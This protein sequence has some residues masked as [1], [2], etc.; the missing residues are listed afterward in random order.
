M[1]RSVVVRSRRPLGIAA[2]LAVLA[3]LPVTV[4]PALA[5]EPPAPSITVVLDS[6][7]DAAQDVTFTSCLGSGCGQFVLDDDDDDPTHPSSVTGG[8]LSPGTYTVQQAPVAGWTLVD[9]DCDTGEDV[10][11]ASGTATIVLDPTEHVTCTFYDRAPAIRI[12]EESGSGHDLGFT[13]CGPAGCGPFTLD[14]D[15]DPTHPDRVLSVPLTP[16]EYTVTQDAEASWSLTSLTCSTGETVDLAARR[17]TID[18]GPTEVVT[19]T[20]TNVTQ[21]LT[22]VHDTEPDSPQD[23]GYTSCLG[24]GC[25]Q[26]VLDD[27]DD[28][29]LPSSIT[30]EGLAP[31]TY[32]VTQDP[33]GDHD[34]TSLTC[35]PTE[36]TNLVTRTATVTITAGEHV[37]CTFRDE[38]AGPVVP[39]TSL[40]AG[41]QQGCAVVVGEEARCWGENGSGA[42][43]DGSTT[44]RLR[45]VAVSD[46]TGSGPLT[47]VTQID[48]A[49]SNYV[50]GG[51][52][53]RTCA[54]LTTGQARCWG[55]GTGPLGD[56][57]ATTT[58]TRPVVVTN[59]TG[60]GPLLGVAEVGTGTGPSA[61]SGFTCARVGRQVRCW[62]AAVVA[63]GDGNGTVARTRPT[64]VVDVDGEGPLTGVTQ[65]S[66]GLDHACARL[67]SGQVR[68]WGGNSR[69]QLGNGTTTSA[70]RAVV[71]SNPAGTG[72]LTGVAEVSAGSGLTCARLDSGEARCWG[73]HTGD[74]TSSNRSRPVVVLDPSGSAPLTGVAHV[75]AGGSYGYVPGS[76]E[77]LVRSACAVLTIGE[78]RCWGTNA[79]GQLGDGTTTT[80]LHPV[81]VSSPSGSG[82]LTGVTEVAV[83]GFNACALL[84]GGGARCWGSAARG[85][86]TPGGPIPGGPVLLH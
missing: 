82:A 33:I 36:A 13:G 56:V 70:S 57:A 46:P 15:E 60:T 67:T 11:L 78:V 65:L 81:A 50:S 83:G 3:V 31:G 44:D 19:C 7:P 62:G 10:D 76:G 84:A 20:F 53:A 41:Q 80:R 23:F 34:L 71:V 6:I 32:T 68:C 25:G 37:V 39:A 27:D 47:G 22:I 74:G 30:G 64:S 16:G 66:V 49:G 4:V 17:V 2:A 48:T 29:T 61:A 12:I 28:P 21:S 43:G 18:L 86:G 77:A 55:V 14:D 40:A 9:I 38:L 51:N 35:S 72:P 1:P 73:Q 63:L 69:G 79:L 42:L 75:S 52:T 45:P 59:A 26:F 8:G 58:A 24:S 5:D 85:D 54:R